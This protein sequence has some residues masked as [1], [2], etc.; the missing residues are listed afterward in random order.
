MDNS[1][2]DLNSLI[3]KE[4]DEILFEKSLMGMLRRF[5]MP[6]VSGSY[7]LD[8]MTWRDLDIYLETENISTNNFFEL[9]SRVCELLTPVKMSFR[10]ELLAKTKGLPAGL[11]WGIYL[12]NERAGAWKIDIWGVDNAEYLRL[13]K[14]CNDIKEALDPTTTSI[15]LAI[16]SQCWQDPAYRRS[17]TSADI[18]NAVMKH[19]V[20]DIEGFRNY[21]ET[22]KAD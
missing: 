17:Y 18:Y 14:Y 10:N 5:G 11:Y 6:H 22:N 7:A 2:L 4:A 15:I 1:L 12:G 16:K 21:L 20:T 3:K 8:L 13:N 9:G 19:S